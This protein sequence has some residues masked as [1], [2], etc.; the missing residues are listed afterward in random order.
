M[1]GNYLIYKEDGKYSL[2]RNHKYFYQI[3]LQMFA[4]KRKYCDFVVWSSNILF[5][6]R[7]CIDRNFLIQAIDKASIGKAS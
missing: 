6:E 2:D 4:L 7:I 3:Q 1:K 5:V